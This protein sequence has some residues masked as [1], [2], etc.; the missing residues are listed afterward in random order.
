MLVSVVTCST[1]TDAGCLRISDG[2]NNSRKG[3]GWVLHIRIR[4]RL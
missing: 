4:Q 2:S 3:C 1:N